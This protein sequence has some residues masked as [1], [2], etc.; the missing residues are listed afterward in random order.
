MC[1]EAHRV[2]VKYS[3]GD[4]IEDGLNWQLQGQDRNLREGERE[5][6]ASTTRGESSTFP[7][8]SGRNT[9]GLRLMH[10]TD[11]GEKLDNP[12]YG[13][14]RTFSP[15]YHLLIVLWIIQV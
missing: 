3:C 12:T 10:V 14:Y 6:G 8:I 4:K 11:D 1:R 5:V 9:H 2:I 15:V 7:I 13:T